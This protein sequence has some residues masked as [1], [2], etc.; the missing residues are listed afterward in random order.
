AIAAAL[1]EDELA[2]GVG[3]SEGADLE[4]VRAVRLEIGGRPADPLGR[5]RPGP[6]AAG[7]LAEPRIGNFPRVEAVLGRGAGRLR[8]VAVATVDDRVE[9]RRA[10]DGQQ[11]AGLVD[12]GAAS[13]EA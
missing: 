11:D 3:G 8:Q 1:V 13:V 12:P 4:R 9:L 10:L 5:I 6:K 2:H 7:E